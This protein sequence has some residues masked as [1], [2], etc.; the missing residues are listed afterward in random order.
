MT[1]VTGT[2][3]AGDPKPSKATLIFVD[4]EPAILMVTRRLLERLGYR[5]SAYG[6]AASALAA[7][8]AN[9][10]G[11]DLILTDYGL[12]GMNGIELA[13]ALHAARHDVPVILISGA[14]EGWTPEQA[15]DRGVSDILMKPYS[16]E[17]LGATLRRWHS[18]RPETP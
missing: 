13:E 8:R 17:D 4:D 18:R 10:A 2:A 12:P 15:R 9:P 5:V 7:F 1:E 6:D 14:N 3:S 11:Y 16:L